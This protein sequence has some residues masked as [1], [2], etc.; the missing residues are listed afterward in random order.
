M[1]PLVVGEGTRVD[2]LDVEPPRPADLAGLAHGPLDQHGRA[3]VGDVVGQVALDDVHEEHP[4]HRPV[5]DAAPGPDVAVRVAHHDVLAHPQPLLG[6]L[7]QHV[8]DRRPA[9]PRPC[10]SW[11]RS[12]WVSRATS[13]RSARVGVP[14]SQP[15]GSGASSGRT[16]SGSFS[17]RLS[18]GI[19]GPDCAARREKAL[20][21]PK[22]RTGQA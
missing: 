9:Q 15:G 1:L 16:S 7:D 20:T 4:A 18:S 17:N 12:S 6:D 14:T 11:A 2:L 13:N 22:S 8:V 10:R 19:T 5:V 21:R 3:A